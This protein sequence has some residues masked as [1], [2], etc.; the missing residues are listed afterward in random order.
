MLTN[1]NKMNIVYVLFLICVKALPYPLV[2][3][4]VS[5]MSLPAN[6]FEDREA[7]VDVMNH[8]EQY[9]LSLFNNTVQAEKI[10]GWSWR[11]I[12]DEDFYHYHNDPVDDHCNTHSAVFA[13]YTGFRL[14]HQM[15]WKLGFGFTHSTH[16]VYCQRGRVISSA[17]LENPDNSW[18]MNHKEPICISEYLEGM[19][20]SRGCYR[21]A[22]RRDIPSQ[23]PWFR[24][25]SFVG[26]LFRCPTDDPNG[27][28]NNDNATPVL[29]LIGDEPYMGLVDFHSPL[30]YAYRV[31]KLY[32]P[33]VMNFLYPVKDDSAAQYIDIESSYETDDLDDETTEQGQI[34]VAGIVSRKSLGA[35]LKEAYKYMTHNLISTDPFQTFGIDDINLKN[36]LMIHGMKSLTLMKNRRIARKLYDTIAELIHPIEKIP[37]SEYSLE[38]AIEML[39]TYE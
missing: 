12:W 39:R 10:V 33:D 37:T 23:F 17:T 19:P 29:P 34:S 30:L 1:T 32:T 18:E 27:E 16:L 35:K 7:M 36:I 11:L 14:F 2:T 38:E 13:P 15:K 20:D 24:S 26:Y 8:P 21:F 4:E 5:K 22:Y 3:N 28:C 31:P 9:D 25:E 6:I